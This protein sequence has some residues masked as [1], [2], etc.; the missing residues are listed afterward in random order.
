[1]KIQVVLTMHNIVSYHSAARIMPIYYANHI[2][3]G[4]ANRRTEQSEG[5][6]C[7]V[8]G[9]NQDIRAPEPL[10]GKHGCVFSLF[11]CMHKKKASKADFSLNIYTEHF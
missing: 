2:M 4:M 3:L 6:N 10:Q 8:R 5:I 9:H 1:M 11:D 7:K